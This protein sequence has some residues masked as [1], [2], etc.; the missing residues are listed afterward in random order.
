[1][2]SSN[3]LRV[4]VKSKFIEK[5]LSVCP[6]CLKRIDADIARRGYEYFMDKRCNEHGYFFTVIWRGVTPAFEA[7]GNYKAPT[8]ELL[9]DCPVGCGLCP[10][11]R[12][13]T[14]CAL[15]EVTRRCNLRCPICFADSGTET[16][17]PTIGELSKIFK[18]LAD[19]GNTFVQLSGGEPTVREDLPEIVAAARSAGCDTVQLNTNGI[20]LGADSAFTRALREAGLSFAFMQFD[21]LDDDIYRKLRG[22]PLLDAKLSAIRVCGENM[23]GVT[24][25]PTIVP[26]V[27]DHCIGD[28]VTFGLKNSPEVRGVHFQPVSYFGRYPSGLSNSDRITLPEILCAIESQTERKFLVTDFSPSSCDHPRCG[29]HGDFVVLPKMNIMKIRNAGK[30]QGDT[31]ADSCCDP[32]VRGESPTASAKSADSCCDD[33]H[34]K[35]RNYIARRWKRTDDSTGRL[36]TTDV[37]NAP[38]NADA[39]AEISKDSVEDTSDDDYGDMDTFL[40]RIK[41]HGFTISAMAF[42]DAYNL[43]ITR[44]RRCSLHVADSTRIVPFCARYLTAVRG[45]DTD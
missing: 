41:S 36:A 4:V 21:G 16:Q 42:Q 22:K 9:P 15:V 44:L 7:W 26:G 8:D 3:R 29:F 35:N 18:S 27:N 17:E 25:V 19:N 28:I 1:M 43:D 6:I 11:H 12:Q 34:L 13:K 23:I 14:C 38:T 10:G 39:A 37:V 40:R 31:S 30:K 33:S 24:L 32:E 2:M 5:T 45:G 20:R